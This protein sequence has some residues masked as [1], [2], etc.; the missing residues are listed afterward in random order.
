MAEDEAMYAEAIDAIGA[1]GSM[2][3]FQRL[4][5]LIEEQYS[6]TARIPAIKAT[7]TYGSEEEISRMFEL[8]I[9]D[10]ILWYFCWEDTIDYIKR[11]RPKAA[12]PGLKQCLL[13]E[14]LS[15]G[16][17]EDAA[18]S[19]KV[20][21][22][23]EA[24]ASLE[25]CMPKLKKCLLDEERLLSTREGAASL[26]GVIDTEE[27]IASLEDCRDKIPKPQSDPLTR[28]QRMTAF[29]FLAQRTD[30]DNDLRSLHESIDKALKVVGSNTSISETRLNRFRKDPLVQLLEIV[31]EADQSNS[32]ELHDENP[33]IQKAIDIKL[34]ETSRKKKILF[35]KQILEMMTGLSLV[36]DLNSDLFVGT[37]FKSVSFTAKLEVFLPLVLAHWGL[38]LRGFTSWKRMFSD[39]S[40][41][42]AMNTRTIESLYESVVKEL[43]KISR[44]EAIQ[45]L[46]KTIC[47]G[48]AG[49][50][51]IAFKEL[52]SIDEEGA[53]ETLI[54]KGLN[55]SRWD[56]RV[57]TVKTLRRIADEKDLPQTVLPLLRS[58]DDKVQQIRTEISLSVGKIASENLLPDL[59]GLVTDPLGCSAL[60][61]IKEIQ[62]HCRFYNYDI[63]Q[64]AVEE[65]SGVSV[66]E[67]EDM[68]D[69]N[70]STIINAEVVQFIGENHGHVIGKHPPRSE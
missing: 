31:T 70:R 49:L 33:L 9:K 20:I 59:A 8:V 65:G 13:S 39:S 34:G 40:S 15:Q 52:E 3:A 36:P 16:R 45:A 25:D 64:T 22:T 50:R 27:A 47:T 63:A 68:K 54:L 12:I 4:F 48:G 10:D 53:V 62:N 58:L 17:R 67:F 46:R 1:I 19:L 35:W 11:H 60:T 29:S 61:A 42:Q 66:A 14:K 24:I 56:V 2:E 28:S 41:L 38:V 7:L 21:G 5:H 6:D 18:S 44:N 37:R 57:W 30:P 32:Q 43:N 26:L 51:E 55:S 23:E 69:P